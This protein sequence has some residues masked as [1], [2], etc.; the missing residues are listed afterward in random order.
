MVLRKQAPKR[1]AFLS[2]ILMIAASVAI[3]GYLIWNSYAERWESAVRAGESVMSIVSAEIERNLKIIDRALL[4]VT[5]TLERIDVSNLPPEMRNKLLFSGLAAAEYVGASLVLSNEGNV[6]YD[7]AFAQPRQRNVSRREFFNFHQKNGNKLF[8]A[9]PYTVEARGGEKVFLLSRGIY[10]KDGTFDGAVVVSLKI[11]YFLTM[12]EHV[13]VGP[14]DY[15]A[16]I[17]KQGRIITRVPSADGK[18]DIGSDAKG[19]PVLGQMVG[20]TIAP[21]TA[22]TPLDGLRRHFLSR[23][24]GQYPLVL[25]VGF[26]TAEIFQPWLRWASLLAALAVLSAATGV[27]L[28]IALQRSMTQQFAVEAELQ[29]LAT[30]DA[31]TGLPNRRAF[32]AYLEREWARACRDRTSVGLL[33][34]DIDRFKVINDTLGHTAGDDLL[35]LVGSQMGASIHRAGDF[36]ARYGGEEFAVILPGTSLTGATVI[37]E[38]LRRDIEAATVRYRFEGKMVATASIGVTAAAPRPHVAMAL[39]VEA[40]DKALYQAKRAGRN[41]VCAMALE[42]ISPERTWAMRA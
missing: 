34:V 42:P 15:L 7:S 8:I 23:Q 3:Q 30:T 14:D 39:L 32:D 41:Q 17:D 27:W 10:R 36:C 21:F 2:V 28:V 35:R 4:A 26:S 40:A 37:A 25:V 19:H 1:T 31:L 12:F 11:S 22:Q 20:E 6:L 9:G 29:N 18:G 16:L 24:L 13:D 5:D 33:L 38:R